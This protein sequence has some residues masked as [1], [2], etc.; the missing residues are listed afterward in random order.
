MEPQVHDELRPVWTSMN[1]TDRFDIRK[2]F[3]RLVRGGVAELKKS[4]EDVFE[5]KID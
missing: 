5:R 2:Q 1:P 4:G 3:E